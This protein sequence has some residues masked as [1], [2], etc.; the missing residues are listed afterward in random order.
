[1]PFF[2]AVK[3]RHYIG[4]RDNNIE[5]IFEEVTP[6]ALA[7]FQN[8]YCFGPFYFSMFDSYQHKELPQKDWKKWG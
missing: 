1:M 4:V 6:K 7:L 3:I 2:V 5:D 8:K